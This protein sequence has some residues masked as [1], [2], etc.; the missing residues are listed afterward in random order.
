[1]LWHSC[2][3]GHFY[4]N[5]GTISSLFT[6]VNGLVCGI[7]SRTFAHSP[8]HSISNFWKLDPQYPATEKKIL[9]QFAT[10]R[11]ISSLSWREID[12]G[13]T[14]LN[15][16]E[17]GIARWFHKIKYHGFKKYAIHFGRLVHS[18]GKILILWMV[19]ICI[20]ENGLASR[21][22]LNIFEIHVI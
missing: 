13:E 1:M 12:N 10:C 5:Q 14:F 4:N 7:V 16:N 20:L 15:N 18:Q 19:L 3:T 17:R 21:N 8:G 6:S 11:M 9:W 22:I 2:F